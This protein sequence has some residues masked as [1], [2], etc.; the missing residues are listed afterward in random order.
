LKNKTVFIFLMKCFLGAVFFVNPCFAVPPQ[1][2]LQSPGNHADVNWDRVE[3]NRFSVY[4]D[5]RNPDIAKQALFAAEYAYPDL[6]LLLGVDIG[7]EIPEHSKLGVK[8]IKSWFDKVPLVISTQTDAAAFANLTT[9]NIELPIASPT[10]SSLYQHEL[11]HRLMYEHMDPNLG[12]A[13]R[14]F[15]LAMI[16]TWWMEGL[17]EYLTESMGRL[18][19]AGFARAM[20]RHETF[21]NYDSLHALYKSSGDV[22]TRGYVTSG[23]FFKY[24]MEHKKEKNLAL[25]HNDLFWKTLTP[26]FMNSVYRIFQNAFNEGPEDVYD[27]FKLYEKKYWEM[28]IEGMPAISDF[29]KLDAKRGPIVAGYPFDFVHYENKKV[30]SLLGNKSSALEWYS[31]DGGQSQRNNLSASGGRVFSVHPSDIYKNESA[32]QESILWTT[33]REEMKNGTVG[34]QILKYTYK[35][36]ITEFSDGNITSKNISNISNFEN[37]F[38]VSQISALP[39]ASAVLLASLRGS[40]AFMLTNGKQ[41]KV[42]HTW[43]VGVQVKMFKKNIDAQLEETKTKDFECFYFLVDEDYERTKIEKRCLNGSVK[44]VLQK[45]QFFVK[46]GIDLGAGKLMLLVSWNNL[47]AF[48]I[49]E[50]GKAPELIA[51]LPDYIVRL[52]PSVIKN[53]I[54]VWRSLGSDYDY[55]ELNI[56]A[57][58]QNFKAWQSKLTPASVWKT[59]PKY[60]PYVP[61]FAKL[62]VEMR[63]KLGEK[64]ASIRYPLTQ[65]QA[66]VAFQSM[67]SS[68]NLKVEPASYRH[69]HWFSYPTFLPSWFGGPAVGILSVPFLEE[70]ERQRIQISAYYDLTT[71]TP[72]GTISYVNQRI[73]DYFGLDVFSREKFNG[74]YYLTEQE[75]NRYLFSYYPRKNS[76]KYY[77]S[78]RETGVGFNALFKFLPSSVSLNLSGQVV[79]TE[80]ETGT[81]NAVVG[82]QNTNL[83]TLGADLNANLYEGKFYDSGENT[84]G[85]FFDTSGFFSLGGDYNMSFGKSKSGRGDNLNNL[86]FYKLRANLNNNISYKRLSLSIRQSISTTQGKFSLLLREVYSPY[87]TYLKG[88]GGGLQATN[89]FLAGGTQL[90]A[91]QPGVYQFRNSVDFSFPVW[92]IESVF[93]IFY[94]QNIRG[95]LVL[96]RGGTARDKNFQ[97]LHFIT[98]ASAAARLLIDIKGVQV[99]PSLAYGRMIGKPEWS[100]FTEIAFAQLF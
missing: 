31:F 91:L 45:E 28:Y 42:L 82:V 57:L 14:A 51:A 85:N 49:Y 23:L 58:K 1:F 60:V 74:I 89:F 86:K 46:D 72:S 26:P 21:L 9:Q 65:Q 88:A 32:G 13:G 73:F 16:P 50:A 12:V 63:K 41:N 95:E 47:Q 39:N 43:P 68:K 30:I 96:A 84:G 10:T 66:T 79:K 61:P 53:K 80:P 99:Y 62:A 34:H 81:L 87:R 55:F 64:N 5:K 33:L 59:Q 44:E 69:S 56:L 37:P 90:F 52:E 7:P 36:K 67:Q 29:A 98:S 38:L 75:E 15:T 6:S 77:S 78:L 92:D 35:G 17:P 18:E 40:N 94:I 24:L 100:I 19:T 3:S 83:A 48:I 25:I 11:V 54:G 4:F 93:G 97:D 2:L 76:Y 22:A 8:K 70:M 71:K 27:K 20:A